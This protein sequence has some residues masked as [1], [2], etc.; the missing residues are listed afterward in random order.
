MSLASLHPN[1]IAIGISND[2]QDF[3]NWRPMCFA[4]QT[5]MIFLPRDNAIGDIV[6]P[7]PVGA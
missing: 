6:L 7:V 3:A 4:A 1:A 2:I 5:N